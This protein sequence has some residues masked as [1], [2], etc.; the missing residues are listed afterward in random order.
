MLREMAR[1]EQLPS[2][3]VELAV[4]FH[5]LQPGRNEDVERKENIDLSQLRKVAIHSLHFH[6]C[7]C[8]L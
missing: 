2:C 3:G 5:L 4:A 6:G 1:R 8:M 7:A